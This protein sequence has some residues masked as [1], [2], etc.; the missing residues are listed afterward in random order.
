MAR[1]INKV[2]LVGNLG[3]DPELRYTNNGT[4]VANVN[5]ATNDSYK[6][7]DGNLIDKT[8]WHRLVF[9]G[10]LAEI[11]DQYLSKGRQVYVEGSL[12]TRQWEDEDGN[13]KYTTEI[14]VREMT[15]LG[16]RDD[17]AAPSGGGK[18]NGF[19]SEQKATNDFAT[20]EALPF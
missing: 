9:W 4:A 10:R 3:A 5:L 16:S 2:I 1:G 18:K 7:S 6:D 13:T 12:Q 20:D 11:A 8:E 14:K 15:M 19:P 17:A